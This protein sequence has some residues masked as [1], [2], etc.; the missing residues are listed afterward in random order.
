MRRFIFVG[1][2]LLFIAGCS[3][4]LP[5][6]A[7]TEA[8]DIDLEVATDQGTVA[9]Q[10]LPSDIHVFKGI[11]YAAAPVDDLRWRAP[12]PGSAWDTTRDATQFGKICP[13]PPT[14]AALTQEALPET[15]EDCLFL[16]VWTPAKTTG[17]ALP[18]MVWIH[19]GG[20]SI[21]WS[22]Q[23]GYDGEELAKRDVVLVSINY[24][25]GPLGFLALPE[26][27]AESSGTSGNY[28]F[29]DQVAA[30]QWVQRNIEAFGGD[31]GRVT[32]F[33][34]SAGGT[35]VVALVASPI[36]EGLIHGAIAQSPWVTDTN[37]ANLDTPRT[38]V[39]SAEDMGSQWIDTVAP[40][41][42]L[43]TLE[44]LRATPA[45]ELVAEGGAQLPMYITVDG[46]FMPDNVEAAFQSGAQRNVPLMIGTNADEGTLFMLGGYGNREQFQT[47]AHATYGD[48]ADALLALYLQEDTSVRDAANQFLTDTWF[49]RAT[50]AILG[51]MNSVS[52]P[53]FQY[54]FT[55]VRGAN[56]LGAHH[57]AEIGYVF[58]T[59]GL[60]G[61]Q[62]GDVPEVVDEALT[63]AMMGYWTQFAKSGDPNAE[64]LVEWP[65]YSEKERSF[66]ELGDTIVVGSALGAERLDQLES[67]LGQ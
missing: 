48:R 58:K 64:G 59:A 36:T 22:H 14:I 2:T 13:Q 23:A 4:S 47:A 67:I 66:L 11:P 18:V 40:D 10:R 49:L 43:R 31:P 32:I 39:E 24:R 35:S 29:L 53:T 65:A 20:L 52:A 8:T 6:N 55:R 37:V 62:E 45:S 5:Q 27:S 38:F 30:L 34:E 15:D 12:I 50:R 56:P 9:G 51:G 28:G 1:W 46:T 19:G 57:A 33:G 42:E 21:G 7:L 17:D 41:E 63:T 26:L 60:L 25:L 54:H 44:A 3:D 16:N 61:A